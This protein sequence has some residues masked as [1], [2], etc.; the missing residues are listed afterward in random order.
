MSNSKEKLKDD[1]PAVNGLLQEYAATG[2]EPD[3]ELI[4]SIMAGIANTEMEP[5]PPR[6]G[7]PLIL[8]IP[9]LRPIA[10]VLAISIAMIWMVTRPTPIATTGKAPL[11]V[12]RSGKV[13]TV[14]ED[15]PLYAR[16]EVIGAEGAIVV[17]PDGSTAQLDSD[18]RLTLNKP[19]EG[20]RVS[21]ELQVGR[22]LFRAAKS[23]RLFRVDAG[24]PVDVVGTVFG[25]NRDT[26]QTTVHVYSGIVQVGGITGISVERGESAVGVPDG[27]ALV[28]EADPDQ[29]LSWAREEKRFSQAPLRKVAAWLESN[30]SFQ[31]KIAPGLANRPVSAKFGPDS[32]IRKEIETLLMGHGLAWSVEGRTVHVTGAQ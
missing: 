6:R 21:V 22:A 9:H 1:N 3:Q 27:S 12:E 16:D 28:S 25:V 24:L 15:S 31:F 29:A 13:R 19:E 26:E 30:S 17:F 18:A 10:A 7:K 32:D 11:Q 14:K 5:A 23:E 4:Q 8:N 2:R 20:E